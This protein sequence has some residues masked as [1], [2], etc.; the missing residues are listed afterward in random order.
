MVQLDI[1]VRNKV[2]S[3]NIHAGILFLTVISRGTYGTIF[4]EN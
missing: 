2:S 3:K 1:T 4:F